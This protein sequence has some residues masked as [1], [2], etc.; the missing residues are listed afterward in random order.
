METW[1]VEEKKCCCFS[2]ITTVHNGFRIFWKQCLN[3]W[4]QRWLRPSRNLVRNLIPYGL[5]ILNILFAQGHIKFSRFF[6][7]IERLPEFLI[8]QSRFFHLDIVEGKNEFL[9]CLEFLNWIEVSCM[10]C[11]NII[12]MSSFT[13]SIQVRNQIE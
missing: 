3:L 8:L 7:K 5:W 4:A 12:A 9:N 2:I 6:L 13:N 1:A 10:N 11:R